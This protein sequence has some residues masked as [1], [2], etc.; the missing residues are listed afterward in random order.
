MKL[1]QRK[2]YLLG[3][4]ACTMELQVQTRGYVLRRRINPE[5]KGWAY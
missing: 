1:K 5:S 4:G 2:T 3:L